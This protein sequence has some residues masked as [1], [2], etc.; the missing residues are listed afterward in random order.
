MH[1]NS[2]NNFFWPS[3]QE[4]TC[5]YNDGQILCIMAEPQ[6]VNR[7]SIHLDWSVWKFVSLPWTF[8]T[9]QKF[10]FQSEPA[11]SFYELSKHFTSLKS[12]Y[13]VSFQFDCSI[14]WGFISSTRAF[15]IVPVEKGSSAVRNYRAFLHE[16]IQI[17]YFYIADSLNCSYEIT[18]IYFCFNNVI[19]KSLNS[20]LPLST[21]HL[22]VLLK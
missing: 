4:D 17:L 21:R 14:L 19:N 7:C 11:I 10:V 5:W 22:H 12:A 6:A 13:F 1:L 15:V 20:V 9:L 8:V 16:L 18:T 3:P 2:M